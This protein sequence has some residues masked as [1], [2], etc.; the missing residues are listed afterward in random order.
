M[1]IIR[2]GK[3]IVHADVRAS[4]IRRVYIRMMKK[5]RGE[6]ANL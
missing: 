6:I 4:E 3:K 1:I 5:K 2:A